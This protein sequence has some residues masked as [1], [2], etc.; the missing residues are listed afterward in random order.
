MC[1]AGKTVSTATETKMK[2][3]IIESPYAGDVF[4]NV[5]YA[6]VCLLDSLRRGE[7]PFASHLLYTQVL[8]DSLPEERTLGIEAGLAIGAAMDLTAVYEDLG[9]SDGMVKG[10]ERAQAAGRPVE[11]RLL[12]PI[13]TSVSSFIQY[14]KWEELGLWAK[15]T[16]QRPGIQTS[17][18]VSGS[19]RTCSHCGGGKRVFRDGHCLTCN[20]RPDE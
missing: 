16:Q 13:W 18:P 19:F 7:A 3:V 17:P 1:F 15:G 12:G 10:I 4:L 2:R 11:R 6:R 8:N 14:K 9:V 20:R 5:Q